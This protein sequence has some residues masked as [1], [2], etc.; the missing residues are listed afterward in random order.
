MA[1]YKIVK[2]RSLMRAVPLN[3]LVV[4]CIQVTRVGYSM[5]TELQQRLHMMQEASENSG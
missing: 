5:V 1:W 4:T 2:Q 3:I